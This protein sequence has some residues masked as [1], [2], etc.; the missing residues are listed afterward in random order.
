MHS[1]HW[2]ASKGKGPKPKETLRRYS[3]LMALD[4]MGSGKNLTGSACEQIRES[5]CL[6]L[7]ILEATLVDMDIYYYL[8]RSYTYELCFFGEARQIPK[9]GG[10]TF[11]LGYVTMFSTH[12]P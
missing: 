2:T 6:I 9:Q 11:S 8:Y 12:Q 3:T 1:R 7:S 10:S 4:A 5:T